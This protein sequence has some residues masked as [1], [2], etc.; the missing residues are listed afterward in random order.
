MLS[1]RVHSKWLTFFAVYATVHHMLKTPIEASA[2]LAQ[3][4]VSL[5]R[6]RD[7]SQDELAARAALARTNLANV[8]RL[9]RANL[10]LSTLGRL[11]DALNVDVLDL[12]Y[13]RPA[14]QQCPSFQRPASR[15]I[16]NLKRLRTQRG[17]SQ[18][19]LSIKASYFRTYVGRLENRAASPM[20][21]DLERLAAALD[22]S[23]A[24][25]LEPVNDKADAA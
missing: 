18:E 4:L 6:S 9:Q 11:A 13:E 25:L 21:H 19:A 23:I 16:A 17:L 24:E 3:R 2:M 20:V 5:R 12:L 15:L 14:N 10:R 1:R 22:V 8:E 7:L